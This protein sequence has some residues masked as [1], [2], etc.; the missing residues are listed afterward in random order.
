MFDVRIQKGIDLFATVFGIVPQLQQVADFLKRHVQ[1][2]AMQDEF[3]PLPILRRVES[4]VAASAG[5]LLQQLLTLV[6]PDGL[7]GDFQCLSQFADFQSGHEGFPVALDP[8]VTTGCLIRARP[9]LMG[10]SSY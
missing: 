2:S 10:T 3:K 7:H 6:I 5:W 8:E 1:R 9:A 4:I